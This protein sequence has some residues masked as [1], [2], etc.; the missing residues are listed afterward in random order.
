MVEK[1]KDYPHYYTTESVVTILSLPKTGS[2]FR[3][4]IMDGK[5]E[6]EIIELDE[7]LPEGMLS[8]HPKPIEIPLKAKKEFKILGHKPDEQLLLDLMWM[9]LMYY[10]ILTTNGPAQIMWIIIGLP[11]FSLYFGRFMERYR[12][13]KKTPRGVEK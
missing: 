5:G 8:I 1:M 10:W 12:E 6:S 11:I 2:K 9:G 13:L 4:E 7:M 3:Y